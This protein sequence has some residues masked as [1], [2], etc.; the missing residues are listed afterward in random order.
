MSINEIIQAMECEIG[1]IESADIMLQHLHPNI[2][3]VQKIELSY[4]IAGVQGLLKFCKNNMENYVRQ[5]YELI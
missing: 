1:N 5:V 3:E 4:Y 2:G